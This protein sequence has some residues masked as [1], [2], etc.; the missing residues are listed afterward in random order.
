M[1]EEEQ[2]LMQMKAIMGA[3]LDMARPRFRQQIMAVLERNESIVYQSPAAL[4][5]L[6]NEIVDALIPNLDTLQ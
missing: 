2:Q 5:H 6:C 3:M 1:D 4:E